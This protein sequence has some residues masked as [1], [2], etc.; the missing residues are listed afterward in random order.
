[1]KIIS[2]LANLKLLELTARIIRDVFCVLSIYVYKCFAIVANNQMLH[3]ICHVII[4]S[5]SNLSSDI[6]LLLL[7]CMYRAKFSDFYNFLVIALWVSLNKM[8]A[9]EFLALVLMWVS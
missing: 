6:L 1:M 3:P 4:Y 9:P 5:S 7:N 2:Y 8:T